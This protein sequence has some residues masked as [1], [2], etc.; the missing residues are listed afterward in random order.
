MRV[1][2]AAAILLLYAGPAI[3]E[4]EYSS[5]VPG[6]H[7]L[8]DGRSF[9]SLSE[10]ESSRIGSELG[11]A[12]ATEATDLNGQSPAAAAG[13]DTPASVKPALPSRRDAD[14]APTVPL[15]QLCDALFT[16]AQNNDL[17]VAFFANLIWQESRLRDDAVSSKGA[18]GIAQ[19]MP[20]VAVEAGLINPF[21]PLQAL[22]ASAHLLRELRDQFG[23]LGYVAAA[24]NAGA[25]RVSEWL[26]RRRTLPRETRGYVMNITGRS[27]EQ[28]QKAPPADA[29][30]RFTRHLPCRDLPA[31]AELEQAQLQQAEL[32]PVQTQQAQ[33]ATE[34]VP[35]S[36]PVRDAKAALSGRR[37]EHPKH[38]R[39]SEAKRK[40]GRLASKPSRTAEREH[41]RNRHEAKDRGHG[42]LH[43]RHRRA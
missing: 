28:W 30:L 17:P 1:I 36:P 43:G 3:S 10:I 20:R 18:L 7:Y 11:E 39:I 19:F 38:E 29:D 24:Y 5:S 40:R 6:S 37:T 32:D 2:F 14:T 35:E 25:K 23:N 4:P 31:F 13:D 34:E 12:A 33:A 16:S 42:A 27:V 26:E 9:A 15:D 22:P 41:D 21:D 8:S